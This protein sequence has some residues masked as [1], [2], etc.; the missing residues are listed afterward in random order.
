VRQLADTGLPTSEVNRIEA[1]LDRHPEIL[2]HHK[3][4]SRKSGPQREVDVHIKVDSRLSVE[5]AHRVAHEAQDQIRSELGTAHVVIHVEPWT[6]A[7]E[8]NSK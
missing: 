4:R 1:I 3:L 8:A 6:V 7:D 5:T 2:G